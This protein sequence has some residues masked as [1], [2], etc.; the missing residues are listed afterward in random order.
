MGIS[1]ELSSIDPREQ[2]I[3]EPANPTHYWRFRL[4]VSA[5]DLINKYTD[6]DT[7]LRSLIQT[8]GRKI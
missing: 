3:N 6:F 1:A 4:H 8:S 5:E 2:K 7:Q